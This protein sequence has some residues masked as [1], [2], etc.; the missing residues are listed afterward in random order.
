MD[1]KLVPA[2]SLEQQGIGGKT[3]TLFCTYMQT[4]LYSAWRFVKGLPTPEAEFALEGV[5]SL[6]V[7]TKGEYFFHLPTSLRSLIL[8]EKKIRPWTSFCPDSPCRMACCR[9]ACRSIRLAM[10]SAWKEW[11]CQEACRTWRLAM[12]STRA[13][14]EWPCQAACRTWP[15]AEFLTRA[16]REWPCQAA[17]RTWRWALTSTGAWR[18]WPCQAAYRTWRS[19]SNSTRAWREWPCQAA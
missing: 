5:T 9:T 6:E 2:E 11:P 15:F 19:V 17:C 4:D 12:N 7:Q 16:W 13:W 10:D 14:R 18:E 3:A 8:Q 1:A